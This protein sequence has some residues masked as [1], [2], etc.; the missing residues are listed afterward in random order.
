MLCHPICNL[1]YSDCCSHSY[2]YYSDYYPHYYADRYSWELTT[3]PNFTASCATVNIVVNHEQNVCICVGIRVSLSSLQHDATHY[4]LNFRA[5][6]ATVNIVVN[7]ERNIY[8]HIHM[9]TYAYICIC[10]GNQVSLSL[11]NTMQHSTF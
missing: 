11:C 3:L 2:F 6:C 4:L 7:H 5:S 10:V 1:L 8:I 9:H